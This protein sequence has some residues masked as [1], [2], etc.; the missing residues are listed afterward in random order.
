MNLCTKLNSANIHLFVMKC[1]AFLFF[2]VSLC[3]FSYF[4]P[5]TTYHIDGCLLP[6][7]INVQLCLVTNYCIYWPSPRFPHIRP[8]VEIQLAFLH[9]IIRITITLSRLDLV[10]GD[11]NWSHRIEHCVQTIVSMCRTCH[12]HLR[13]S[14]AIVIEHC[15]LS[16]K[17]RVTETHQARLYKL[18][19][20][21]NGNYEFMSCSSR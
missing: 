21:W 13:N 18:I 5:M 14:L 7:S 17:H 8:I 19:R 3:A 9:F 6:H 10:K 2:S 4:R 1:V 16:G 20:L 12:T 15:T 11:G